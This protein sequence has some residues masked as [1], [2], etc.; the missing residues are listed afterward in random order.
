M[1]IAIVSREYPPDSA[2]GGVA[3]GY[4]NLAQGLAQQGNQVH[5][6]CQAADNVYNPIEQGGTYLKGY[7]C[8]VETHLT[9]E[10]QIRLHLLLP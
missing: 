4:Y 7:S 8:W 10:T 9:I 6:I 5:V 2:W 1:R 3:T